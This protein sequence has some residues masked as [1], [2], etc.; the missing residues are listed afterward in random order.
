MARGVEVPRGETGVVHV[1]G[2]NVFQGYWG[3]PRK[4]RE[5]LSPDGWFRTGDLGT[6]DADGY[7]TIVGRDKDLV[8]SGGYNVY[9]KEIEQVLD[10]FPGV[11]E[12]CVIGAPHPDLGETLVALLV[13]ADTRPDVA[14]IEAALRNRLAGYKRPRLIEVVDE[15]PRNAMGKVQKAQLRQE[16][17]DR[18]D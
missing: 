16:Y 7:V 15:L 17:A 11:R 14:S 12:S 3:K 9:P 13:P 1:K 8:I 18:F 4:T 6:M 2:P 5:E 10:E